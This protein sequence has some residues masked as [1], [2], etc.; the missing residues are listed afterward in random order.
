MVSV[1]RLRALPWAL[2]LRAVVVVGQRWTAVSAKDRARMARLV[3]ASRGR[4]ANLSSR[5]RDELRR[6]LRKL[7]LQG[8]GRELLPLVGGAR[9]GRKRG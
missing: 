3:R 5:E 8:A 4:P 7:D 1:S 9:R 6:L 2:L